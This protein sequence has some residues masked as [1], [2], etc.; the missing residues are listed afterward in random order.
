MMVA[1]IQKIMVNG[2]VSYLILMITTYVISLFFWPTPAVPLICALL[3]PAAVRAGLPVMTAAMVVCISGQGMALSS[4][5]IMQVAPMIS[6]KAAGIETS[7]IADKVLVLSL[8]TG[9]SA[10]SIV[11]L[12][13]RKAIKKTSPLNSAIE[14]NAEEKAYIDGAN[15]I[16]ATVEESPEMIKLKQTWGKVFAVLVPLS[17]LG[18]YDLYVPGQINGG[19]WIRGRKRCSFYWRCFSN[20]FDFIYYCF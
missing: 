8:I 18:N 2:H 14:L 13:E 17:M 4:D 19:I 20:S 16:A 10:L 1:P 9:L 3:V 7:L 5:Y 6:A 15:E 11:Y 12:K